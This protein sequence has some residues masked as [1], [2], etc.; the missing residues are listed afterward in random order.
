MVGRTDYVCKGDSYLYSLCAQ[1]LE[2]YATLQNSSADTDD[3]ERLYKKSYLINKDNP[4]ARY[5]TRPNNHTYETVTQK[6]FNKYVKLTKSKEI[7]A[8]YFIFWILTCFLDFAPIPLE[9]RTFSFQDGSLSI[10]Y[11]GI[12]LSAVIATAACYVNVKI[13][14]EMPTKGL[15]IIGVVIATIISYFTYQTN[16]IQNWAGIAS[17][18]LFVLTLFSI[19]VYSTKIHGLKT[20]ERLMISTSYS[21]CGKWRQTLRKNKLAWG[22]A[23]LMILA[24]AAAIAIWVGV[25]HL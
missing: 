11:E 16:V 25:L 2:D 1:L 15:L 22:V 24:D 17:E 23:V 12:L 20:P 3:L 4:L 19:F 14:R 21:H 9:W 7:C 13:G 5:K 8:I 6:E 18:F 10:L